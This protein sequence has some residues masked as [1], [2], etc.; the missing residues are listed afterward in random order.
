MDRIIQQSATAET[1]NRISLLNTQVD[2]LTMPEL[3]SITDRY[4]QNRQPLHIVGVNA[5]KINQMY[6]DEALRQV[7]NRCGIIHADGISIVLASRF[8]KK[9]LPERIAG[10]DLM[11]RLTQQS[12]EKGYSIFLLGAAQQVV[13]QT[14]KALLEQ[15]PGLRIVGI[16]NGYFQEED[17]PQISR[18]LAEANPHL[19]FVGITSPQKEHIIAYLQQEGHQCVFMG[20][21]GSF[22]VL[23]G[24]K[25]R[26][27]LWLRRIGMEWLFRLIQEPKRLMKRYLVGNIL[28][29]YAVCREKLS[30]IQ[31]RKLYDKTEN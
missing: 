19:V 15:Y 25:R 2:V 21:G 6:Q 17:W 26:A 14:R 27:P 4:I 11:E 28:F 7:V 5:D 30:Q 1:D 16:H 31:Q 12:A 23:S 8:L 13:E 18:I 10:I 20:V 22:D 24:E 3:I 29:L 9:P